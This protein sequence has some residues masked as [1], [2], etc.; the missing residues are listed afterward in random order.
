MGDARR[1]AQIYATSSEI[2]ERIHLR[3]AVAVL[4]AVCVTGIAAAAISLAF[5]GMST[6]PF[7]CLGI[8]IPG[9]LWGVRYALKKP[10]T[11]LESLAYVA[12]C[13][14]SIVIGICVVTT[15][16]IAFVKLAWL[17]A[18]NT[19]TFV[20]HGRTAVAI[21][22]AVTVVATALAVGGAVFRGDSNAPALI[23]IVATVILANL[24]AAWVIYG[25]MAQF[26]THA[27]DRD[28]LARHDDLT[29]LL[30]RRGLQ[31]ACEKWTGDARN[32][33]IVVAV[34]DLDEF[35][36]INDT[37][38]HGVGDEVLRRTARQLQ[39]LQGPDR[40]LAR[41]GGDEFGVVAIVC[42]DE[43][44]NYHQVVQD[45][46]DSGGDEIPV[47]SSVGVASEALSRL[48]DLPDSSL[49][50]AVADLLIKADNAM[51]RVKRGDSLGAYSIER[52]TEYRIG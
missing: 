6:V 43:V 26:A 25:G 38:G 18:A 9:F 51:Y 49:V 1:G 10:A 34:I 21:Q 40:F 13:D 36:S 11:Y 41:L 5:S 7:L 23:T 50:A 4:T 37:Y 48:G 44:L 31:E 8:S 12:Y 42:S 29:G 19:Y 32:R 30:N 15:S 35:K 28:H 17:V 45:A 33:H 22:S 24:I 39:A 46:M 52:R 3:R 47:N 16:G 27:D 14:V 20:F 2:L